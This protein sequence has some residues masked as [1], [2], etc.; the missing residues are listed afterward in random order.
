M[1]TAT[2]D[3]TISLITQY[4]LD[5]IGHCYV[6]GGAPGPMFTGC[7]DCSG[8]C[9]FL[10]G[11]V[12]GQSIPGFPHGSYDGTVHG[13]STVGWL[14]WQGQGVGSIARGLAKAGDLAVWQ[15]HMGYCISNSE[16][17][18]AQNPASGVQRSVIDGFIPGE[19]LVILRLAVVGPGGISL[20]LPVAGDT[21]Q[22]DAVIRDIAKGDKNFVYTR[23]RVQRMGL[24]WGSA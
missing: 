18:S 2:I 1:T 20:P 24:P 10:W 9:N 13:P 5:Q 17:V 11:R 22:I 23:M 7:T 4:A 12:G 16:M 19:Q 21:A 6:F 15:T 3:D 8:F 14:E